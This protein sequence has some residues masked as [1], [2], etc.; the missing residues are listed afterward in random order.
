MPV[1]KRSDHE[2]EP[3]KQKLEE[4]RRKLTL[5]TDVGFRVTARLCSGPELEQLMNLLADVITGRKTGPFHDVQTQKDLITVTGAKSVEP[6]LFGNDEEDGIWCAEV[7]NESIEAGRIEV[8]RAH[9]VLNG[10]PGGKPYSCLKKSHMI[11]MTDAIHI[12]GTGRPLFPDGQP[13]VRLETVDSATG[14]CFPDRTEVILFNLRY[15][16]NSKRG[17]LAHDFRETDPKKM[18]NPLLRELMQRVKYTEKG[19]MEMCELTRQIFQD[20]KTEG[21][22]EGIQKGEIRSSRKTAGKMLRKGLYS[23]QEIVELTSLSLSEVQRLQAR[24]NP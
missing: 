1:K 13:V 22:Q 16:G 4:Y 20:G 6:D 21:L 24:L 18:K 9:L 10:L 19:E 23:L 2:V 11:W 8:E 7:Q 12:P 15:K 5:K 3:F 14:R 17:D